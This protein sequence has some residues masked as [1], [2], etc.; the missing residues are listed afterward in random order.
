[1]Y[2]CPALRNYE[3]GPVPS[4][5]PWWCCSRDAPA[6]AHNRFRAS[7]PKSTHARLRKVQTQTQTNANYCVCPP[8]F[9]LKAQHACTTVSLVCGVIAYT[10]LMRRPDWKGPAFEFRLFISDRN[11]YIRP[12]TQRKTRATADAAAVSLISHYAITLGRVD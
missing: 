6:R 8:R 3:G 10:Y 1:M 7:R 5:W 2:I 11:T 9:H 12:T 4:W